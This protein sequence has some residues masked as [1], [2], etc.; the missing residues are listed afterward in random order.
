M[1]LDANFLLLYMKSFLL[2]S[3]QQEL[4]IWEKRMDTGPPPFLLGFSLAQRAANISKIMKRLTAE[5]GAL[6]LNALPAM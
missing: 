1:A 3:F 6:F 5:L 4:L 2:C